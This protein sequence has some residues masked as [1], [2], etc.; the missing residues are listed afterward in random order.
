M[1]VGEGAIDPKIGKI[2]EIRL[3]IHNDSENW[4]ILSEIFLQDNSSRWRK[5][6]RIHHLIPISP[7]FNQ[8][9]IKSY[10]NSTKTKTKVKTK[11]KTT[12]KD[13]TINKLW[14]I[15]LKLN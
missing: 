13:F 1:G 6:N 7:Q 11:T 4:A 15:T 8:Y 10:L 3:H 5:Y 2:K 12:R 14:Y 9:S